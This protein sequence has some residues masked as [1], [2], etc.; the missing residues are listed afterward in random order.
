MGLGRICQSSRHKPD[1]WA[2]PLSWQSEKESLAGL[3]CFLKC[4]G[5]MTSTAG[6][7]GPRLTHLCDSL[8]WAAASTLLHPSPSPLSLLPHSHFVLLNMD[9]M[10]LAHQHLNSLPPCSYQWTGIIIPQPGS[11]IHLDSHLHHLVVGE[12]FVQLWKLV[13]P[14]ATNND[15]ASLSHQLLLQDRDCLPQSPD[16]VT[17]SVCSFSMADLGNTLGN[18][19]F[20][21]YLFVS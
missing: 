21:P 9:P 5:G 15:L 11:I 20:M 12:N 6:R 10:I 7:Q 3:C 1:G 13:P 4:V 18:Y 8:I 14:Q 19:L 17:G 2:F 16:K